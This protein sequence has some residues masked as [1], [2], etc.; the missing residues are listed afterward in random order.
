MLPYFKNYVLTD[1][2]V[3]AVDRYR[4][5]KM[6]EGRLGSNAINKTLTRLA[7]ILEVA[8][9]YGHIDRNPAKGKIGRA[10][11][12]KPRRTW[13]E[14]EQL[15]LLLDA[16]DGYLRP[17][18][19]TLAGAGLR[20]GE[21]VA[22]DWRDVNLATATPTVQE[23]K[24]AAGEGREVNLPIGLRE[25][26]TA[27]KARSPRARRPSDPV[28]ISRARNGRHARQTTRNV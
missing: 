24:T 5:A 27:W 17:I 18:I 9:E 20:I 11:P 12:T 23:S 4:T 19:A 28:F 10:K 14:P 13:V 25:D 22:L 1:I 6:R 3:E 2:T 26:L 7:L 15:G 21:A 16:A 8:Q